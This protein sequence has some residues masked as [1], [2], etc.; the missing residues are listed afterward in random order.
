MIPVPLLNPKFANALAAKPCELRVRGTG[1]RMVPFIRYP[2]KIFYRIG[3]DA[4]EILHHAARR[5][6][7]SGGE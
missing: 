6:P 7:W 3:T 4:V 1:V 5:D 2:Y